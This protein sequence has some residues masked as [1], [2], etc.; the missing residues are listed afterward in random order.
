MLLGLCKGSEITYA[1]LTK[2]QEI[3]LVP[4]LLLLLK[5]LLLLLLLLLLRCETLMESLVLL[6]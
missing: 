1:Q 6:E 5:L 4:L 3:C 2:L